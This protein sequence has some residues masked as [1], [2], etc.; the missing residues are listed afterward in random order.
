MSAAAAAARVGGPRVAALLLGAASLA[1][2]AAPQ[3]LTGWWGLALTLAVVAV[4]ASSLRLFLTEVPNP[5]DEYFLSPL[6]RA[7]LV[8]LRALRL[9]PWEE[10]AVATV[11]W[12]EALD[13]ARP[14]HTAALGAALVAYLLT[15]HVAESGAAA[16]RLLRGHAKV[17]IV[18]AC[19]LAIGAGTA[20]LPATG[21]GAAAA[22]LSVLAAA[23]VIA[24][25]ALV[26]P[27]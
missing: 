2:A 26:L 27:A 18:G 13:T 19:L 14:W 11:V 24:A 15:V 12:L 23:A 3:V 1:W 9:P 10:I 5:E 6:A 8:S 22:L 4:A 25:A 17:L 20:M 7:W 21:P 16:G